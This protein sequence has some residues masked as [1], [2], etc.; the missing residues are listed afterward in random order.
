[1]LNKFCNIF[2]NSLSLTFWP[3]NSAKKWLELP[4]I[5]PG[6]FHMRSERST[7]ELQPLVRKDKL[8]AKAQLEQ[9]SKQTENGEKNRWTKSSV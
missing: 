1:M 4:G 6:T 7:T 5:E 8:L 3:P 9:K 2:N